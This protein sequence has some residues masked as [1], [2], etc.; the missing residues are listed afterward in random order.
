M[1]A[2]LKRVVATGLAQA[3]PCWLKSVT[4]T[5]AG[6]AA[7][8][9]IQDSSAGGGTDVLG[10]NAPIGDTGEWTCGDEEG[11]WFVTGV[12]VTLGG[13]GASCSIEVEV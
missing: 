4:V 12:Y 5:G 9:L 11:V 3:G 6:V 7:T 1:A 2:R 13:A 10:I 8:A